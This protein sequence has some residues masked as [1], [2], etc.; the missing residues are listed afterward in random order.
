MASI[1]ALSDSKLIKV[2]NTRPLTARQHRPL[3]H[4]A[5]HDEKEEEI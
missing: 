1:Q 4:L 5:P 3:L 2:A